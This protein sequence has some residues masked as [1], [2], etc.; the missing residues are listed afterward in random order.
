[1]AVVGLLLFLAGNHFT[2][3][4]ALEVLRA[5]E[6]LVLVLASLN[7]VALATLFGFYWWKVIAPESLTRG[8]ALSA[9]TATIPSGLRLPLR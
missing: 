8:R 2:T 5:A 6:A 1:M 3:F 7:S 9:S 4:S